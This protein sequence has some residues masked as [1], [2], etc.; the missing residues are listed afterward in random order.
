MQNFGLMPVVFRKLADKDKPTFDF[1]Y[2]KLICGIELEIE[3]VREPFFYSHNRSAWSTK[4]DASLR[5]GGIEFVSKPTQ[6][7]KLYLDIL[8]FFNKNPFN[9]PLNYSDR[10]SIHVHTNVQDFTMEQ[11][12]NLVVLY[13]LTES[14]L[15]DFVGNH[16]SEGIY[17]V[18]LNQTLIAQNLN[19][20]L[21]NISVGYRRAWEKYLAFNLL[22][23]LTYG[24]VE[25][26]HMH[27]TNDVQKIGNWL[28]LVSNLVGL[29]QVSN[30]SEVVTAIK[31]NNFDVINGWYVNIFEDI[32]TGIVDNPQQKYLG[33]LTEVKYLLSN[34]GKQKVRTTFKSAVD[35][36][37]VR[38][39]LDP[40]V[41]P[42]LQRDAL[43][44]LHHFD[45]QAQLNHFIARN[46]EVVQRGRVAGAG[47]AVRVIFDDNDVINR[48][49]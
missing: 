16:R 22:P 9:G 3:D 13:S 23:I 32:L 48:G 15:F 29:A 44:L 40:G 7:D 4:Q 43:E 21:S 42:V 35:P 26:R 33:N 8:E 2:P 31:E 47:E 24:T 25:F 46:A 14:I 39:V 18:P 45:R 11:L 27:G 41:P 19:D 34:E 5:N 10:T 20:T 28:K 17:C 36:R 1:K 12:K 49:V 6:L 37:P 30:Y 38:Y